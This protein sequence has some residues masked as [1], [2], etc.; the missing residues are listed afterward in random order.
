M[1]DVV[2]DFILTGLEGAKP[3]VHEVDCTLGAEV[4]FVFVEA[5][6]GSKGISASVE[7]LAEMF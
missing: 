3:V 6:I 1:V 7:P 5:Q 4:T 2:E